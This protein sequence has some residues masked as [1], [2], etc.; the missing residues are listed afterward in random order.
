MN[1]ESYHFVQC[2][3][4]FS[5][6][7]SCF[8]SVMA[9]RDVLHNQV[10]AFLMYLP[11][12]ANM[13]ID[14]TVQNQEDCFFLLY[15]VWSFVIFLNLVKAFMVVCFPILY[16]WA[17]LYK[18]AVLFAVWTHF[19]DSLSLSNSRLI[20]M[21]SCTYTVKSTHFGCHNTTCGEWKS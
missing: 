12:Y 13:S 18:S 16:N 17:I 21:I 15:R 19:M 3:E 20:G 10:W 8:P 5:V 6:S 7:F 14:Q 9:G 11:I 2:Y 4:M 1:T